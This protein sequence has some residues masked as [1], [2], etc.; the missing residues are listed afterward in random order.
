MKKNDKYG[1]RSVR[2]AKL[3]PPKGMPA[4]PQPDAD[5]PADAGM[6]LNKYVAH[7]GLCSRRQAIDY[8]KAGAVTV[9]GA[10]VTEPGYCVQEADVVAYKGQVIKPEATQVYILMNKPKGIL[11]TVKDDRGRKTVIDLLGGKVGERVFPVGRLDRDTTGLL[12]LTNDG[13]LSKRLMHP[14]HKVK[15]FYHVVLDRPVSPDHLASIRGGV[16]L[17]DGLAVVDSV[18]YMQS[19]DKNEVGIE[20]HIGKNRIVR[21]IFEHFGYRI[22][23]LDRLSLGGLT[24]K[25]LPRGWWRHLTKQ[26]V[27][28]LKHFS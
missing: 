22:E 5:E 1:G 18:D 21:R 23:R 7:C 19:K 3:T 17:E 26:E 2:P 6:R 25:N 15:K 28:L 9:N 4:Q 13:D 27:I 20:L 11:T 10:V 16:T 24:K 14:S 8:V 12:L